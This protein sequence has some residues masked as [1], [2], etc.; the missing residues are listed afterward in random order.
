MP[1]HVTSRQ[2]TG[3]EIEGG[4]V[5]RLFTIMTAQALCLSPMSAESCGIDGS[6]G[7][8]QTFRLIFLLGFLTWTG[9]FTV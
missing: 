4:L 3:C 6:F 5:L 2:N 1:N 9:K 7:Q 8:G